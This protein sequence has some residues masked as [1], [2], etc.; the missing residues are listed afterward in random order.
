M[1]APIVVGAAILAIANKLFDIMQTVSFMMFIEEEGIQ[2]RGFGIMSLIREK[3]VDEVEE[4]LA[5]MK[6]HTT[7][8]ETFV[9]SW[10]WIAPYM[11]PTYA[12]Y[13]QSTFDQID[14]WEAWLVS[15]RADKPKFGVRVAS[16]PSS[17]NIYADGKD[18]GFL[19]PHSLLNLTAGNH[20]I[21]V[22][23][24]SR[25]Q[26]KL[27]FTGTVKI[28]ET[29][30]YEVLWTLKPQQGKIRIYSSPSAAM[31]FLD[32]NDTGFLTPQ[33]FILDP[34]NYKFELEYDSARRGALAYSETITIT[35]E[36]NQELRWIL[37]E[38]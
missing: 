35:K 28:T 34:G 2:I 31:I 24:E 21:K 13:V 33:T 30:I 10:G 23:K 12:R 25:A 11:Q 17:A 37:D 15:V 22:T 14:A 8:L 38:T 18:T 6:I 19:T 7:N 1:V 36:Y 4:Q 29:D 5:E 26:G 16:S 3:L 32:G 9:D 27:E 20:T